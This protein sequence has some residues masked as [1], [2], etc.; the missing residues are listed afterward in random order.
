MHWS[1]LIGGDLSMTIPYE[2]QVLFN[3]SDIEVKERMQ[4]PVPKEALDTLYE[5]FP[6]FRKAYEPN[7]M[8]VDEFDTYGATARTLRSFIGSY[9]DFVALIRDFMI[10]NP[11]VK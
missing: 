6:D 7:G 5:K 11:D 10:P 9:H 8:T 1:E 2:W 3:G 4:N